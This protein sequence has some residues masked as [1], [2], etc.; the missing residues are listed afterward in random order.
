MDHIEEWAQ[1]AAQSLKELDP[2]SL[3]TTQGEVEINPVYFSSGA[4]ALNLPVKQR[5]NFLNICPHGSYGW[6]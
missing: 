5:Q 6:G 4:D 3:K 1:L 2:L